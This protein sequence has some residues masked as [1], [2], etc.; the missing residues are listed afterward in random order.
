LPP[1]ASF[2]VL[3]TPV[4]ALHLVVSTPASPRLAVSVAKSSAL[5]LRPFLARFFFV[6]RTE[7]FVAKTEATRILSR[8]T[9][10]FATFLRWCEGR[11]FI[12]C[13]AGVRKKVG[14]VG[15]GVRHVSQAARAWH[16]ARMGDE[17]KTKRTANKTWKKRRGG[18]TMATPRW[19]QAG[20]FPWSGVVP[21]PRLVPHPGPSYQTRP[22]SRAPPYHPCDAS[23]SARMGMNVGGDVSLF[24]FPNLLQ[25]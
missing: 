12:S 11:A 17:T 23:P 3:P 25:N 19:V 2:P 6:A 8:N 9:A 10:R 4:P 21:R 24:R 5:A 14:R 13:S 22:P 15:K 20:C 16:V 7:F 18:A 1:F